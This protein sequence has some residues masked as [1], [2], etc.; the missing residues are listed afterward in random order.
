MLFEKSRNSWIYL[1]IIHE[2]IASQ[3]LS[4]SLWQTCRLQCI[5]YFISD[6]F[7][8]ALKIPKCLVTTI[9]WIINIVVFE[10]NYL[11][12]C[13]SNRM[14]NLLVWFKLYFGNRSHL[15]MFSK[16][17]NQEN[18]SHILIA[19]YFPNNCLLEDK[20]ID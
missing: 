2:D 20:Y 17:L 14:I 3:P 15:P 7:A 8:K 19:V 5:E 6:K 12:L 10:T 18:S 9:N 4:C 16:V 1:L 11:Y 13:D